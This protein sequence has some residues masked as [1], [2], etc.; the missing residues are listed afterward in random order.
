MLTP[1]TVFALI[2]V[3]GLACQ[4]LAWR[5]RLPAILFL[6]LSGVLLGPVA[7][8]VKPDELFGDLL[9]PFISLS[10]A[11]ILFEGSLTLKFR[12]LQD[13]GS[14]VRNMVSYGA[15]INA[16]ITT[17]A[18]HFLIGISWP[19][20]ALFGAIM[21]VT[22]PTVIVPL[23]RTVKPN[24]RIAN[25][26]RWEGI[27][28]DPLGALFAVLVFEWI[29][30]QQGHGDWLHATWIFLQTIVVGN[31]LGALA[32]YLFGLLLRHRWLPEYLQNFA[33]LATVAGVFAC[34]ESLRHE[35]GLLTVT[36]MGIWLANMRDVNTEDILDFKENLTIVLVSS[37]FIVLAARIDFADVELL[38]WGSLGVLAVMQLLS[39]P[40]KVF[41]SSMGSVFTFK[42]KLLLSW[43]GPRGIVAAAV[44]ALFALKL[45]QMGYEEAYL[46][47]P[48]AFT[49]IMGTVVIQSLTARPLA[50][51]LDVAEPDSRGYLIMG[52]NPVARAIAKAL[53]TANYRVLLSDTYWDNISS[54]RMADL[55]TFYGSL[56]SEHADRHLDLVGM[57]G[58]LGL[59]HH[60]ERNHLGAL[61]FQ[62]EFPKTKILSLA[63]NRDNVQKSSK[64]TISGNHHG[65]VLFGDDTTFSKLAS[66]IAK[67]AQ[68][69]STT[70]TDNFTYDDWRSHESNADSIPLF[71]VDTKGSVLWFT[72]QHQLE[73]KSQ[74]QLFSLVPQENKPSKEKTERKQSS[75]KENQ[76]VPSAG[77]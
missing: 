65:Q 21:V 12:Q 17:V 41:I 37:L 51:A 44:T 68:I 64:R 59:S 74:W 32:G 5:A 54:A 20:A 69:K 10:V 18:V 2:A 56:L 30:A 1:V 38:G 67:G 43:V 58:F 29:S 62:N 6:L 26:L 23:L 22:G 77:K 47:V 3:T 28:I 8:V 40:I 49:V 45:E 34:A 61:K 39:R 13:I 46:L 48:L 53:R 11:I 14:V 76:E 7:N 15:L 19:L 66:L 27:V 52:A 31:L 63:S 33:T 75:N 24:A 9:F 73:P 4:W 25:A 71:C 42:E 35:S 50:L 36:I 70:L 55:P 60:A 72:P 16:V 57:G